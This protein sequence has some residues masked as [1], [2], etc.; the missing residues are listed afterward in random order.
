MFWPSEDYKA[1]ATEFGPMPKPW[2]A[3]SGDDDGIHYILFPKSEDPSNMEY[4]IEVCIVL[5]INKHELINLTDN[6]PN[7]YIFDRI[8]LFLDI[9]LC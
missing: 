5:I 1:Q 3:L 2:I 9:Y 4:S 8:F 7:Y 6:F